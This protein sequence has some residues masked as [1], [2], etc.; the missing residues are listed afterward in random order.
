[1]PSSQ[2]SP[3]RPKDRNHFVPTDAS[4]HWVIRARETFQS[5]V[6]AEDSHPPTKGK[7]RVHPLD[8]CGAQGQREKPTCPRR[9]R[10]LSAALG[11]QGR[12]STA[13]R[14]GT[15]LL[16]ASTE[17]S[18]AE[19]YKL[20]ACTFPLYFP[21]PRGTVGLGRAAFHML[22]SQQILPPAFALQSVIIPSQTGELPLGAN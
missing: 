18:L 12:C 10:D 3:V 19:R 16:T 14:T 17:N 15:R 1:M 22:P 5:Q 21:F 11:L 8:R 4:I 20:S 7:V 2:L 6:P 13:G 9:C